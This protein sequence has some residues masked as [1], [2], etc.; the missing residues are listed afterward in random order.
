MIPLWM[1][2]NCLKTSA[3]S[4][5]QFSQLE[6]CHCLLQINKNNRSNRF[7][8]SYYGLPYNH[9]PWRFVSTHYGESQNN[10]LTGFFIDYY[11]QLQIIQRIFSVY[12]GQPQTSKLWWFFSA[13]QGQSSNNKFTLFFAAC[14]GKLQIIEQ[15][16]LLLTRGNP[17]IIFFKKRFS[18]SPIG[19]FISDVSWRLVTLYKMDKTKN[20][21]QM[22]KLR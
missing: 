21:H 14:C 9:K 17:K 20:S 13:C 7:L 2:L 15:H 4:R 16:L 8:Y 12:Y 22:A 19:S 11:K 10:K 1:G 18:N 3:T 6:F 5:R